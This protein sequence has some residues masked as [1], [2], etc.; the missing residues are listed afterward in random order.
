MIDRGVHVALWVG[1]GTGTS[2]GSKVKSFV[3]TSTLTK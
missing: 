1:V 2:G 3:V